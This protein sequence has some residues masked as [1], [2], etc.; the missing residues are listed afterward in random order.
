MCLRLFFSPSF[1]KYLHAT[2]CDLIS[3]FQSPVPKGPHSSSGDYDFPTSED[4]PADRE[5]LMRHKNSAKKSALATSRSPGNPVKAKKPSS[6]SAANRFPKPTLETSNSVHSSRKPQQKRSLS[7][8]ANI[9]GTVAKQQ[10]KRARQEE[11]ESTPTPDKSAK[12]KRPSCA[13]TTDDML[14]GPSK[15]VENPLR[16]RGEPSSE[17]PAK[18]KREASTR[19][20]GERGAVATRSPPERYPLQRNGRSAFDIPADGASARSTGQQRS[21]A[22]DG[23]PETTSAARSNTADSNQRVNGTSQQQ[24]RQSPSNTVR[25]HSP[26]VGALWSPSNIGSTQS[27][28]QNKSEYL[29]QAKKLKYEGDN[30]KL[31]IHRRAAK[32]L[33]AAMLF[34]RY[35]AAMEGQAMA[36]NNP[37]E[38]K[39]ARSCYTETIGILGFISVLSR[40]EKSD[41][42]QEILIISIRCMAVLSMKIFEMR[43]EVTKK[44]NHSLNETFK[45]VNTQKATN[46]P[47]SPPTSSGGS[48]NGGPSPN[49]SPA[50]LVPTPPEAGRAPSATAA[51]GTNGTGGSTGKTGNNVVGPSTPTSTVQFPQ[52]LVMAGMTTCKF[53]THAID[54]V[55]HWQ[56][57]DRKMTETQDFFARLNRECGEI[58]LMSS[59]AKLI[60]WCERGLQR[61]EQS[62]R[63]TARSRDTTV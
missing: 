63:P 30:K 29:A 55:T 58:H 54:A 24:Q 14:N 21:R 38:R 27:P 50:S 61:C 34:I 31:P 47:V 62:S 33:E 5:M 41:V 10:V 11:D 39:A 56:R 32:Y 46:Q 19:P 23:A 22:T 12:R 4:D 45:S 6:D 2:L 26:S 44:E 42:R 20:G 3:C 28:Q 15:K 53:M 36:S 9:P 43:L 48:S 13:N 51:H 16:R 57:A 7:P 49:P 8:V 40:L 59:I 1:K 35:A 52:R 25:T 37:E 17:Q 18:K 60:E